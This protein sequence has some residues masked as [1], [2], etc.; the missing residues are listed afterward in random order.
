[1]RVFE[2]AELGHEVTKK[3]FDE[4][5]PALRTALLAAQRKLHET[6]IPVIVI[7]S[8]VEGAGK[9]EVVNRLNEW[10]DARGVETM[11]FWDE[12]DEEHERP[13]HWRY[14]RAM[15]ARGRIA[16]FFG[17]WYTPPIVDRTMG[18]INDSRFSIALNRIVE[19]ERMLAADNALIIKL[20]FHLSRAGQKDKLKGRQGRPAPRPGRSSPPTT[21]AMRASRSSTPCVAGSRRR[22]I[23]PSNALTDAA[24]L[25]KAGCLLLSS[26]ELFDARYR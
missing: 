7:I 4:Q 25:A 3:H 9:S 16:I 21:G 6:G 22:S 19:L 12:T 18:E 14:W 20:W 8:G 1:M 23:P 15:P 5:E 2:A 24:R 11:A 17:S 26:I 10:L 13:G